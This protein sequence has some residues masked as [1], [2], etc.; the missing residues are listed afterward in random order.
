[1][2]KWIHS[3][4]NSHDKGFEETYPK[5]TYVTS[6]NSTFSK[7]VLLLKQFYLAQQS[8]TQ[9]VQYCLSSSANLVTMSGGAIGI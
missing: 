2:K 7:L 9:P 1:M 4:T 8:G 6:L 5:E 3:S